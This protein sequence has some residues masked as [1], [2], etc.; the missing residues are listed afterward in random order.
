MTALSIAF[1]MQL[2]A[3]PACT[4]PGMVKEFWPAVVRKESHDD[5]LA[6]RDDAESHF[7]YPKN[8]EAPKELAPRLMLAGHSVGVGL[9]QLTAAGVI[10]AALPLSLFSNDACETVVDAVVAL[11]RNG[12]LPFSLKSR[13]AR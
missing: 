6:L 11:R 2:A 3:K 1:V 5:P 12:S 4:V 9:S 8:V 7:Y 10:A 13:Q